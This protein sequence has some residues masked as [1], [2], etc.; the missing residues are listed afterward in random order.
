MK[1]TNKVKKTIRVLDD[2]INSHALDENRNDMRSELFQLSLIANE[3]GTLIDMFE[4]GGDDPYSMGIFY[5]SL[6]DITPEQEIKVCCYV[7]NQAIKNLSNNDEI[8]GQ[9]SINEWISGELIRRCVDQMLD[10]DGY[11]DEIYP[12]YCHVLGEKYKKDDIIGFKS[13]LLLDWF[14]VGDAFGV[15]DLL[16]TSGWS[17]DLEEYMNKG[18]KRLIRDYNGIWSDY[19]NLFFSSFDI[20]DDPVKKAI[21]DID[22]EE[23]SP[24]IKPKQ[25][26]TKRHIYLMKCNRNGLYKI[27]VSNNPKFREKTLSSEDPSIQLVGS[28]ANLSCNER[29]WHEYFKHHRVRGEWFNLTKTQVELFCRR[30]TKQ[31]SAPTTETLQI[32]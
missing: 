21:T 15:C 4:E 27:G 17:D 14:N 2:S 12:V 19:C 16:Y 20:N 6:G 18:V 7:V 28:W 1:P 29:A 24:P 13:E 10:L 11:V 9:Y 8:W 30:S 22:S 5:D 25:E 26:E 32:Q 23:E 31:Q 3:V